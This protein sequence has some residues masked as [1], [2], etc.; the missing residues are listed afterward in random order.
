MKGLG[1]GDIFHMNVNP[2]ALPTRVLEIDDYHKAWI[3]RHQ[4]V[5]TGMI[6]TGVIFPDVE[7]LPASDFFHKDLYWV[8]YWASFKE[9]LWAMPTAPP[10]PRRVM[11]GQKKEPELNT[12]LRARMRAR[13]DLIQAVYEYAGRGQS[14]AIDIAPGTDWEYEQWK[15]L[16][17]NR[18]G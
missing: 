5:R 12:T 8:V 6:A 1:V 9:H 7:G 18:G 17:M 2:H 10:D 16:P 15:K 3:V 4:F 11:L 14:L 13:I